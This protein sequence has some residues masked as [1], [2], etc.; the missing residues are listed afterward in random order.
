MT[1]DITSTGGDVNTKVAF[2]NCAPYRKC[3]THIND[4]HVETTENSEIIM[5][6]QNLLEFTDSYAE[7]SESLWQL[8]RHEQNM[9]N[10]GNFDDVTTNGSTS[11][12]YQSS[13]SGASTAEG[14][15]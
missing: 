4:E 7:F 11:F 2:K 8:K 1:G 13:L 12:K 15:N 3:V 9:N 10:D 14:A 5:P 6:M